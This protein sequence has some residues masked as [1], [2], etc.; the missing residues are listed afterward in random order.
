MLK[1]IEFAEKSGN[2]RAER[3]SRVRVKLCETGVQSKSIVSARLE[4]RVRA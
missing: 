4:S 2:G 1:A 3:E